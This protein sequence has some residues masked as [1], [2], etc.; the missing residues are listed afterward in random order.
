MGLLDSI[1]IEVLVWPK[2]V[3]CLRVFAWKSADCK[4]AK[5][6][7]NINFS[8]LTTAHVLMSGDAW[9][10]CRTGGHGDG[11]CTTLGWGQPTS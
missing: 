11:G 10:L 9:G 8:S 4:Y 7:L 2:P 1:Q 5:E 3:L 6:T